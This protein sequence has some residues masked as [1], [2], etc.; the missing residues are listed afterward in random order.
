MSLG[1]LSPTESG[2]VMSPKEMPQKRPPRPVQGR[3]SALA[4]KWNR[5]SSR[6]D[7]KNE[8]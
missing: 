3:Y 8:D 2:E 6:K 1:A 4:A 5:V 7:V